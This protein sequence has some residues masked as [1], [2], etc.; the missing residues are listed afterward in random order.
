MLEQFRAKVLNNFRRHR[1]DG[2]RQRHVIL[3]VGRGG[4][5]MPP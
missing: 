3:E 4:G 5:A 1:L 2:K